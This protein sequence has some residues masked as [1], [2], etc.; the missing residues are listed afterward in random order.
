MDIIIGGRQTG[1]TTEMIK[2]SS[3]LWIPIITSTSVRA[4]C[5]KSQALKIGYIIPEPLSFEEYNRKRVY[6]RTLFNKG[7]LV[8]QFDHIL[9]MLFNN[10][11]NAF[12]V[13]K[14]FIDS[15]NET[16]NNIVWLKNNPY[17]GGEKDKTT[18]VVDN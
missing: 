13:D 5:I 14:D 7:I 3:E 17:L 18:K 6:Q 10:D 15:F 12:T 4:C 2:R 9:Q 1:K 16:V 11:I 8:D